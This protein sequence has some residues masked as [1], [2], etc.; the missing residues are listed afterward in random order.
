MNYGNETTFNRVDNSGAS[1]VLVMVGA[2]VD[3]D[4]ISP[5]RDT[6]EK[7][8]YDGQSADVREYV[9]GKLEP[10]ELTVKIEYRKDANTEA[11]AMED[12]FYGT[13]DSLGEYQLNYPTTGNP[14]RKF[15]AI[16]TSV[17]EPLPS[18]EKMVQEFKFKLSGAIE[19]GTWS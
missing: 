8:D 4:G 3:I 12:E 2:V 13:D 6:E 5:K 9:R 19:R 10:G 15:K 16:I 1:P 7:K 18:G 11:K 14:T 17:S